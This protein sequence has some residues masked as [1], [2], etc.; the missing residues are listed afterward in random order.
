[1]V[2]FLRGVFFGQWLKQGS[3]HHVSQSGTDGAIARYYKPDEWRA[4]VGDRFVLDA[5][6][7]YG[8]KSDVVPLPHGRLK[9]ALMR[10]L[11]DAVARFLTRHLRMGSL[12]VAQ[13]RKR[14]AAISASSPG[15]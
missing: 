11:P 4:A 8:L 9:M 6:D 12:L 5:I 13:L 2:G 7:I 1:M 10:L 14:E 3:L 15:R